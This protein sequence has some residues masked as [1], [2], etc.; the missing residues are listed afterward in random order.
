MTGF[1]K[2]VLE[3]K[4]SEAYE[5]AVDMK[6]KEICEDL[7]AISYEAQNMLAYGF[8]TYA[9]LR[10][11]NIRWHSIVVYIL[12]ASYVCL[13]GEEL[14]YCHVKRM[15]EL[16][17][18]SFEALSTMMFLASSPDTSGTQDDFNWVKERIAEL[19]PNDSILK[20]EHGEGMKLEDVKKSKMAEFD[21]D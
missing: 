18:N 2:L 17:P 21:N 15:I 11:E 3:G 9:L 16:N 5:I 20:V 4:F 12:G 13:E 6:R 19:Y 8:A 10:E 7:V 14:A 1:R